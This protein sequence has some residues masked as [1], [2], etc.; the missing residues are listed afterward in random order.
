MIKGITF[1]VYDLL[2]L[3][4]FKLFEKIKKNCDELTVYVHDDIYNIK[5]KNFLY[6]LSQRMYLLDR[7]KTVDRV[8]PYTRVDVDIKNA[9]FDIFFIGQ[10]QKNEYFLEAIEYARKNNKKIVEIKREPNISSSFI[11]NIIEKS[12]Y[13]G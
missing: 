4:H 12:T 7:I 10:D 8:L 5:K 3:G 11:K 1:G 6:S 13:H 2:H 9:N